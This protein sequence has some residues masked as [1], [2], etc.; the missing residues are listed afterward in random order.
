MG[1]ELWNKNSVSPDIPGCCILRIEGSQSFLH[2]GFESSAIVHSKLRN[3][4]VID[5]CQDLYDLI[6]LLKLYLLFALRDHFIF[7]DDEWFVYFVVSEFSHQA[8]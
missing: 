2:F 8:E 1:C 4:G 7:S 5:S 6:K 3:D